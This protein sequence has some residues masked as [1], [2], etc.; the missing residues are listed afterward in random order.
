[1][2]SLVAIA[3]C[4]SSGQQAPTPHSNQPYRGQDSRDIRALSASEVDDYLA[5]SGMGF[6]RAA[7]L[8][9]YPGP[10]HTLQL[11]DRLELSDEQRRAI[12]SLMAA[13]RTEARTAGARVIET[14]RAL[15]AVFRLSVIPD[16]TLLSTR[17][18]AAA[19]AQGDFRLTHL[20]THRRMRSM[21]TDAQVARYDTLRGYGSGAAHSH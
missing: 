14:E 16:P 11:A 17:V 19:R 7:E 6:A 1:M 9:H 21:L 18:E 10:L 12:E 2:I 3:G 8:N 5:G 4:A 15:D 20:E 13:H